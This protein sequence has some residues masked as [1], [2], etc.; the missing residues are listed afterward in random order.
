MA[1]THKWRYY[2]N[3]YYKGLGNTSP[4]YHS[5][6]YTAVQRVLCVYLRCARQTRA[7]ALWSIIAEKPEATRKKCR[8]CFR[9]LLHTCALILGSESTLKATEWNCSK[10]NSTSYNSL[11]K[12]V[13]E[14]PTPQP[15]PFTK[16]WASHTIAMIIGKHHMYIQYW[17]LCSKT[18]LANFCCLKACIYT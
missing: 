11:A 2:Y 14:N 5:A 15:S 16:Y 17:Q 4:L 6:Q 3:Y 9:E 10:H 13:S 8:Q 18:L 1:D 7:H 12:T